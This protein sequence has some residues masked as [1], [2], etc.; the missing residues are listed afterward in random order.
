MKKILLILSFFAAV[1]VTLA[2]TEKIV[3]K[4]VGDDFER[5]YNAADYQAVFKLFDATMQAAL[6]LDKTTEFLKQLNAQVG[7]ISKREFI[8]YEKGTYATYKTTFERGLLAV[9]ISVNAAGKINGLFVGPY[10]DASLPQMA[11]NNTKL[12]LPF[13]DEW[14]V[15]WGGDTKELNYHVESLAQKNAFDFVI[16]DTSNKSYRTDGKTNED[17]Y[18]FGKPL[19]APC[20]GEVV[21]VV[22]GVKEN[23]PGTLNPF[24]IS[25]NT[26]IIKTANNEYL[27]FAH[28]K[29]HSI[30]VKQGQ[31]LKAGDQLGLCGNTGNSSEPHLHFHIQ[32]TEDI[33]AATGVKCYFD[34]ILVNSQPRVDYSPV[35]NDKVAS[36]F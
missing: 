34:N 9:H 33:N 22:D 20:N 15:T 11:R 26:V 21:L 19:Y 30:I 16:T 14:T 32:N 5:F 35:K 6:P 17:Y 2:Q 7:D 36:A 28:F 4:T 1:N 23:T 29:Q 27:F 12:S 24:F 8:K 25:G 3:Y 31:Q 18:A 13:K 10:T